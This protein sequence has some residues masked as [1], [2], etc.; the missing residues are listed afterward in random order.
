[1]KASKRYEA[2]LGRTRKGDT[3]FTRQEKDFLI[4][5]ENRVRGDVRQNAAK[6]AKLH[7]PDSSVA[8]YAARTSP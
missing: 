7:G 8:R 5:A 2:L 3:N 4:H 6:V 1:M